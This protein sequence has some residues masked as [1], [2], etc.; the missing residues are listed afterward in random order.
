MAKIN[1]CRKGKA[2]ERRAAKFLSSLLSI[3]GVRRGQ[4]HA[5][6]PE[7]PDV[8][9]VPG[10]HVEVKADRSIGLGTRALWDACQQSRTDSAEREAPCV[11]WWEHRKGWRLSWLFLVPDTSG[12]DNKGAIVVTV[13]GND[14]IKKVLS[15]WIGF[16]KLLEQGVVAD[17][18]VEPWS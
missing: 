12:H 4:Q 15:D 11:L 14:D 5:G 10:V 17:E 2:N 1:S 8:V 9:G 6:G 16:H 13:A 3:E 18:A 7:S